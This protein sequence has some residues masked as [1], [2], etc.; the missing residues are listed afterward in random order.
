MRRNSRGYSS[1]PPSATDPENAPILESN[2][3]TVMENRSVEAEDRREDDKVESSSRETTGPSVQTTDPENAPIL[4]SN[5]NTVIENRSVEAE[6]RKEDDK[7]ESSSRETT[8]PSVQTETRDHSEKARVELAT[9]QYEDWKEIFSGALN[10]K[11]LLCGILLI[12]CLYVFCYIFNIAIIGNDEDKDN[13]ACQC[14]FS[15]RRCL[16]I[17]I[18]GFCLIWIVCFAVIIIYDLYKLFKNRSID[19]PDSDKTA[20]DKFSKLDDELTLYENHLWLEFYKA[21][22]VGSG[23]Y[24]SRN[25]SSSDDAK[26]NEYGWLLKFYKEFYKEVDK[27]KEQHNRDEVDEVDGATADLDCCQRLCKKIKEKAKVFLIIF[28]NKGEKAAQQSYYFLYPFLVIVRLL[29]QLTLIP[30]LLL[31]MLN[32]DTWICVTEDDQC[33]NAITSSQLGLY[34]AY[35][36]FS[37]YIALLVAVLASTMLRWFPQSKAARDAGASSFM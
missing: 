6:D 26:E 14:T 16:Q 3:N 10:D 5:D 29:A 28:L 11:Q 19:S 9:K 30:L 21:Y 22:S 37:F 23:V 18:T 1:I 17:I 33:H 7:V 32:T 24:E 36:T 15:Q 34:Q 12:L 2:D 4:E 8:G 27:A 20:D 35:M 31:Q 25:L 13:E